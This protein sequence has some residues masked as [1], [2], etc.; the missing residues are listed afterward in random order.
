[1]VMMQQYKTAEN[2]YLATQCPAVTTW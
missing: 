1:M 2:I